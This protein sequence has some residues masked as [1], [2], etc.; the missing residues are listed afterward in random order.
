MKTQQ[1]LR[2]ACSVLIIPAHFI[3]YSVLF[4]D[5][6]VDKLSQATFIVLGRVQCYGSVYVK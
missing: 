5:M 4:I 3:V 1:I 2:M 6:A